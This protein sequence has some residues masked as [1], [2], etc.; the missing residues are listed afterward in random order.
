MIT[1]ISICTLLTLKQWNRLNFADYTAHYWKRIIKSV[2]FLFKLLFTSS[3]PQTKLQVL[4]ILSGPKRNLQGTFSYCKCSTKDCDWKW[5]RWTQSENKHLV[6][7]FSTGDEQQC[8]KKKKK[9]QPL[10]SP[11]AVL[12][13]IRY[14]SDWLTRHRIIRQWRCIELGYLSIA[15]GPRLPWRYGPYYT[16]PVVPL[17]VSFVSASQAHQISVI[18]GRKKW[19]AQTSN[20]SKC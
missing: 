2:Q 7:H 8:V 14:W 13:E 9:W 10:E 19:L 5:N 20:E 3:S 4:A 12:C 15:N 17:N 16:M 11:E 6:W 1:T 18:G